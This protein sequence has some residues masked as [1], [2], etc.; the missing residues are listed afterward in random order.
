MLRIF[1]CFGF[2][3]LCSDAIAQNFIS[4]WQFQVNRDKASD[5]LVIPDDDKGMLQVQ[6][7]SQK[8]RID[9]TEYAKAADDLAVII[10]N[11]SLGRL[12]WKRVIKGKGNWIPQVAPMLVGNNYCVAAFSND[13]WRVGTDSVSG[14]GVFGVDKEGVVKFI[15]AL[16]GEIQYKPSVSIGG[17]LLLKCLVR[18][19][20]TVNG[21]IYVPGF[22]II[23]VDTVGR[24]TREIHLGK[25]QT[26]Y[27]Y[28]E[29]AAND[30][31]IIFTGYA[32]RNRPF[33]GNGWQIRALDSNDRP[34]GNSSDQFI[35][36]LNNN[37]Q[38]KW[39]HRLDT[40][41]YSAD[42]GKMVLLRNDKI[43]WCPDYYKNGQFLGFK[44]NVK[45]RG[46]SYPLFIELNLDGGAIV[47]FKAPAEV[48]GGSNHGVKLFTDSRFD[49]L[50]VACRG[51]DSTG[52]V[53]SVPKTDW[54]TYFTGLLYF[55]G[56][57]NYLKKASVPDYY[58]SALN[59]HRT[60]Y[61]VHNTYFNGSGE[62][63]KWIE[64]VNYKNQMGNDLLV[65]N[66]TTEKFTRLTSVN[67]QNSN[68]IRIYPNPT[69]Q[70]FMV[71]DEKSYWT[72]ASVFDVHG[73]RCGELKPVNGHW[74][75][76]NLPAGL[77]LLQ[78]LGEN[79]HMASSRL[80]INR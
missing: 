13:F 30:S 78:F 48:Q 77:Y 80:L 42:P 46:G 44:I 9:Q 32:S 5:V 26:F 61:L 19:S 58:F 36:C 59:L 67:R 39:F 3:A 71:S 62:S 50:I 18:T 12:N 11:D 79:G 60:N 16:P 27:S 76:G 55:D 35:A 22:W 31:N 6:R 64:G 52:S 24:F 25:S 43:I 17:K 1:V 38:L 53:F 63:E 37:G 65:G 41:S 49:K 74:E 23:E 68:T 70:S 34:G 73:R 57:L 20:D 8:L 2:V 28:Y 7:I 15:T 10:K 66:Y 14:S 56:S 69:N 21:K 4:R 29:I 51:G 47:R 45:F 40:M 75:V 54:E 33:I 72:N